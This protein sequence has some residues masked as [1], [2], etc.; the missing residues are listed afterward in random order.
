MRIL[1]RKSF[2]L[3]SCISILC[4]SPAALAATFQLTFYEQTSGGNNLFDNYILA[5]SGA[6]T[7][8]DSAVRPNN[9]VLFSEPEFLDFNVV[10][11]TS[12]DGPTPH[13]LGVDD[14]PPREPN[15]E[16]QRDQGILFDNSA[17]PL[18]FEVP[19]LSRTEAIPI[20]NPDCATS[21]SFRTEL[22]L[23]DTDSYSV[24]YLSDGTID[25]VSNLMRL[26]PDQTFTR[27]AGTFDHAVGSR[28][29]GANIRVGGVYVISPVPIP[30]AVWLFGSAIALTVGLSRHKKFV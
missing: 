29:G 15:P 20:C 17:Q 12:V 9:L 2:R 27:I 19:N 6:F 26:Y 3:I 18:R 5:G 16:S 21:T 1:S 8:A 24:G 22:R 30:G 13:V 23:H 7:I 28:V 4:L 25:T 11:D 10:M 14:F